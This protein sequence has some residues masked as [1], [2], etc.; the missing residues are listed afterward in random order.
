MPTNK[1]LNTVSKSTIKSM[2]TVQICDLMCD[3]INTEQRKHYV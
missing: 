3:K 2:A 1:L